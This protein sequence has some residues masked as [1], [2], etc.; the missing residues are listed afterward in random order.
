MQVQLVDPTN[1]FLERQVRNY[2]WGQVPQ[3]PLTRR[4][5]ARVRR[6]LQIA[7]RLFRRKRL[8][9]TQYAALAVAAGCEWRAA[10][11]NKEEPIPVNLQINW[12]NLVGE[13]TDCLFAAPWPTDL[14]EAEHKYGP[15]SKAPYVLAKSMHPEMGAMQLGHVTSVSLMRWEEEATEWLNSAKHAISFLGRHWGPWEMRLQDLNAHFPIGVKVFLVVGTWL[16]SV[17]GSYAA[18]SH[19]VLDGQSRAAA[20]TTVKK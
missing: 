2:K 1:D 11:Q 6:R 17:I 7:A 10:K 16:L 8:S 5:R 4:V 15:Y 14:A 19:H 20:I 12:G 3:T 9:N 13:L 18:G